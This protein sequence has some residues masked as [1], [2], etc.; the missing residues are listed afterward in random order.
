M[1]RLASEGLRSVGA[2]SPSKSV[3]SI[4]PLARRWR[5]GETFRV[6]TPARGSLRKPA[7]GQQVQSPNDR[8]GAYHRQP[9]QY[10]EEHREHALLSRLLSGTAASL[11]TVGAL[12][13]TL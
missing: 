5:A 10:P 3:C 12:V 2:T 6:L 13:T 11:P 8:Q 9:C 4:L 7:A 1:V